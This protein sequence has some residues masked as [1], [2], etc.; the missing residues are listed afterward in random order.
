MMM[1]MIDD[2][3]DDCKVDGNDNVCYSNGDNASDIIDSVYDDEDFKIRD[4]LWNL[5]TRTKHPF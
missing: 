3:D 1:M 2:T 5:F 4:M